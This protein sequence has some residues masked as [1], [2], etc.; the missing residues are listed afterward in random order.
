M[1]GAT[2]DLGKLEDE[3]IEKYILFL[4]GTAWKKKN[5]PELFWD[6]HTSHIHCV[7]YI[8]DMCVNTEKQSWKE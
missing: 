1:L 5:H 8:A 3:R 7:H 2:S 4:H 6:T